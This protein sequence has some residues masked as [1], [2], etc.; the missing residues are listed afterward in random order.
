MGIA[1]PRDPG[2]YALWLVA[3]APASIVVG[4]LGTVRVAPN[5]AYIY[6]GSARG[7]LAKRVGRHLARSG[8]KRRWHVDYLLEHADVR[9]AYLATTT[10][11]KECELS[12]AFNALTG[13]FVPIKGFGNSDCIACHS[14]L[15]E[16][17]AGDSP[18]AVDAMVRT[19]F[20]A[21]GLQPV[22]VPVP[23]E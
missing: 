4:K 2:I 19:A 10:S 20:H 23:T 18:A 13:H 6:V 22:T 15:Y 7:G 9:A 3:R 21:C 17:S 1:I 11:R 14:H 5:R 8:K 16:G 12:N